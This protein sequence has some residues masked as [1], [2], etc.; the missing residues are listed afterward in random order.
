MFLN[1]APAARRT[2]ASV[3]AERVR[4]KET[5]LATALSG[6]SPCLVHRPHISLWPCLSPFTHRHRH[7]QPSTNTDNRAQTRT[8][9]QIH[10]RARTHNQAHTHARTHTQSRTDI[11]AFLPISLQRLQARPRTL[12]V[13]PSGVSVCVVARAL[14]LRVRV[15]LTEDGRRVG[16]GGVGGGGWGGA[17][18]EVSARPLQDIDP[19]VVA[20]YAGY[21]HRPHPRSRSHKERRREMRIWLFANRCTCCCLPSATDALW[22]MHLH[23][24]V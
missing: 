24:C 18:A 22:G 10:T 19:K 13:S 9:L 8:Q 16:G 11:H 20:V 21:A 6:S 2:L 12:S 23:L 3:L 15:G 7:R 5:E 4:D 17:P 14:A 1:P